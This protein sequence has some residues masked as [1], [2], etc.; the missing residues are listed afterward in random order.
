MQ[1]ELITNIINSTSAPPTTKDDINL[2]NTT[3]EEN[4]KIT[5]HGK[6]DSD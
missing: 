5:I 6:E 3:R 4:A 2:K 1:N